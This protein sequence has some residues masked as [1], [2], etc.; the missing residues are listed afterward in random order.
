MQNAYG[1]C[2][3]LY[4]VMRNSPLSTKY[5]ENGIIYGVVDKKILP[6]MV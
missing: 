6:K 1:Y 3:W 4:Y 5:L 2:K